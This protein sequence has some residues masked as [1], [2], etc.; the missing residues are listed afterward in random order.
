M[1]QGIS[2]VN[3]TL[4]LY[5]QLTAMLKDCSLDNLKV[6]KASISLILFA[7]A[8][9]QKHFLSDELDDTNKRAFASLKHTLKNWILN[10]KVTGGFSWSKEEFEVR[11]T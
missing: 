11:T 4:Y 2:M 3:A 5:K 6:L 8:Q 9:L 1:K 10:H 7:V